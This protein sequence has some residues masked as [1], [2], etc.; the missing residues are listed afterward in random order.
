[1][2]QLLMNERMSRR[3]VKG[4]EVFGEAYRNGTNI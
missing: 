1:M 2:R 3:A 4:G